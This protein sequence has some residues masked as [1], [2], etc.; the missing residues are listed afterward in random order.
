MITLTDKKARITK[1]ETGNGITTIS[2]EWG[3]PDDRTMTDFDIDI[4]GDV[5]D[6]GDNH[7]A[8]G[9]WVIVNGYCFLSEGDSIPFVQGEE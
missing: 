4:L 3:G 6:S 9:G 8:T 7:R 5:V 2:L 1:I